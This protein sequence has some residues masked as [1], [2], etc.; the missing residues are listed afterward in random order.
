MQKIRKGVSSFLSHYLVAKNMRTNV[1]LMEEDIISGAV[2]RYCS[3]DI[4]G[5]IRSDREKDKRKVKKAK[6]KA[7]LAH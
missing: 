4:Y 1:N 7:K 3:L 6:R 2:A 5:P